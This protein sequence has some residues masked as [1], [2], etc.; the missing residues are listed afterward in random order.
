M[1]HNLT[2]CGDE[3]IIELFP[4]FIKETVANVPI[5]RTWLRLS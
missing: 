5:S 2:I 1:K 3:N 4:Y